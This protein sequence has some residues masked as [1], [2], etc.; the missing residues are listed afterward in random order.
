MDMEDKDVKV[1]MA[2]CPKCS[3]LV[4]V[5]VEHLMSKESKKEMAN[6]VKEG[7]DV[8]T[9]GLL[10]YKSSEIEWHNRELCKI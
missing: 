9:I 2:L 3:G 1:R 4:L 7:C 8:K 10:E 5:S 6:L